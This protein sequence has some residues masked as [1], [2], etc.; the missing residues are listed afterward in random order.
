[1]TRR[2][3]GTTTLIFLAL[4][5]TA[6]AGE[7]SR[8]RRVAVTEYRLREEVALDIGDLIQAGAVQPRSAIRVDQ[9]QD[10]H[11]LLR[12]R[13]G[14]AK[15]GEGWYRNLLNARPGAPD[16]A[17]DPGLN[18]VYDVYVEVRAVHMG[19]ADGMGAKPEDVFPMAFEL[20]LDDGSKH[21]VV[22]A[23]GFPE[24]HYDTEVMAGYQWRLDGRRIILRNLGKP[25]YLYGFRFVPGIRRKDRIEAYRAL[26][27]K[28]KKFTRWLATDHV[29]IVKE[30][31][32]HFGFPGAAQLNNGD[33]VAVYR[34]GTKH[35]V[36][37]TGKNSLSRSTDGGRMW[38]PRV[39]MIDRPGDDRGPSIFQMSD[40]TV[41]ATSNGC[42][43]V[44]SDFGH[45]WSEPM[46]T[47]VSSPMGAV[48]D[49]EGH[50][51]YGG[52]SHIQKGFTRIGGRDAQL[53][54]CAMYRSKDKARSWERVGI[55]TYTL[56]MR[57]PEDFLW[58][59]EPFMCVVPGKFYVMCNC[60]RMP[61]DGF[62]RVIRSSDR[63]RTWG[64]VIQTPVWGKPAHLLPL[65]DGR[66]LMTYGYR[67][68]PWGVRAC[69]S[70]DNGETWQMDDEIIIR[71]DGGGAPG[72][73]YTKT[74]GPGDLGYPVS[75]QLDN[76]RIF[77]VYYFSKDGSNAYIAATFWELPP[78]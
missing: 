49:E 78:R 24:H 47:P 17:I 63:G 33:I 62:I 37:A 59:R 70:C 39:T 74:T 57:W 5:W 66:L 52:Q 16:L 69:L 6:C 65:R 48:E 46:P 40:D 34:E 42:M 7:D 60:N 19:G 68:P 1:M 77:T 56:Q 64:P 2:N 44:S 71:M 54:A 21:Q 76:G 75:V 30:P 3:R 32:K 58:Q 11:W 55:A 28:G 8:L 26:G 67:R 9:P 10:K 18:G 12:T 41:I 50:I 25:V 61:G 23:T 43:V 45:T 35:G 20:A 13:E 15:G 4:A 73:R 29:T 51:V 53:L 22:G 14:R 31:D 36:E 38:L 72:D 27:G